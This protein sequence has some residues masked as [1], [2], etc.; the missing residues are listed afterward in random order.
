[1]ESLSWIWKFGGGFW[2][3]KKSSSNKEPN[4]FTLGNC[5]SQSQENILTI[6]FI[7]SLLHQAFQWAQ[8]SR[9]QSGIIP[10]VF[11]GLIFMVQMSFSVRY[12]QNIQPSFEFRNYLLLLSLGNCKSQTQEN[13]LTIYSIQS[14]RTPGIPLSPVGQKTLGQRALL[15]FMVSAPWCNGFS[16]NILSE[17]SAKFWVS[18]TPK[19]YMCGNQLH[20]TL[21]L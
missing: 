14:L 13:I 20:L 18:Q 10:P 3:V 16:W 2:Y 1:M 4:Y 6:S 17:Y 12:G 19:L 9:T 21:D 8:E 5:E 7:Q 15:F 11:Y